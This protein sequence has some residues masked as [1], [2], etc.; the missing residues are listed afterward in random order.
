MTATGITTITHTVVDNKYSYCCYD[1]LALLP[2]T[3]ADD[4]HSYCCYDVLAFTSDSSIFRCI[5]AVLHGLA[6]SCCG[7]A[8]GCT[9]V[10][11]G[12]VGKRLVGHVRCQPE[13]F[14][15]AI[16]RSP[17]WMGRFGREQATAVYNGWDDCCGWR[18][19]RRWFV[20]RPSFSHRLHSCS[21][22][23]GVRTARYEPSYSGRHFGHV[24]MSINDCLHLN[25]CLEDIILTYQSYLS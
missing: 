7:K 12:V 24:S 22:A 8:S 5:E 6:G 19:M 17:Q 20:G 10:R 9:N 2:H 23:G 1:A 25:D 13:S 11:L 16:H 3:V 18:W 4:K 21:E 15:A 14:V